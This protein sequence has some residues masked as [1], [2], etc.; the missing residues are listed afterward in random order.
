M[1]RALTSEELDAIRAR[2][3]KYGGGDYVSLLAEV[4]AEVECLRAD[5]TELRALGVSLH[6]A[7]AA[8]RDAE[9]AAVVAWLRE[10]AASDKETAKQYHHAEGLA[11]WRGVI[12]VL[13]DAADHIERGE[14]RREEA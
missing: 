7:A 5:M 3:P 1:S 10:E 14:H 13:K 6:K 4:I 11:Y 8:G 12:E 2:P 9:R